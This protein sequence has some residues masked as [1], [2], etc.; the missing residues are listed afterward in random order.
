MPDVVAVAEG[1]LLQFLVLPRA[2]MRLWRRS[3]LPAARLRLQPLSLQA[4][5][6]V[7]TLSWS[8]FQ[9]MKT[10]SRFMDGWV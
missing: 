4:S 8:R 10:K 6:D 3:R 1:K 2:V 7:R 5:V 9:W